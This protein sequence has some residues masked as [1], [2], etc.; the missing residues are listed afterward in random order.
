MAEDQGTPEKDTQIIIIG[1]NTVID[2][3]IFAEYVE[4]W[5]AKPSEDQ[6]RRNFKTHFTNAQNAYKGAHPAHTTAYL[7]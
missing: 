5:N 1:K 6:T 2:T 7:G 3:G 4:R